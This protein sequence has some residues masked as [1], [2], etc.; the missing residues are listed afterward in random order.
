MAFLERARSMYERGDV[1]RASVTLAEGLKRQPDHAEAV[2]WLLHLYVEELPKPGLESELLRILEAQEGGEQL[3]QLVLAEL[4]EFGAHEKYAALTQVLEREGFHPHDAEAARREA[5]ASEAHASETGPTASQS[6]PGV[7]SPPESRDSEGDSHEGTS[8]SGAS[9]AGAPA[10]TTGTSVASAGAEG[11][12]EDWEA[13]RNPLEPEPALRP[14]P[15]SARTGGA[16]EGVD[17]YDDGDPFRER[18]RILVVFGLVGFVL[19]SLFLLFS[20]G[21]E[22]VEPGEGAAPLESGTGIDQE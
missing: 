20:A 4:R 17:A 3:L 7:D 18:R 16:D 12:D 5:A 15:G 6:P 1:V 14:A 11:D 10:A 9:A 8:A 19:L 21:E 2:E 13:F 22:R